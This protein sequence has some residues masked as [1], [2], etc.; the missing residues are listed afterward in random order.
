M[1]NDNDLFDMFTNGGEHQDQEKNARQIASDISIQSDP[2]APP[3][4]PH[5][6][7]EARLARK[8]ARQKKRRR[9]YALLLILAL[10][11]GIGFGGYKVFN[12]IKRATQSTVQKESQS[13]D[14]P[15]P[16]EGNVLFVINEGD[17][18]S[19]IAKNLVNAGVV[20][21]AGAFLKAVELADASKKLQVGSF[22][23]KKK[24]SAAQV[25]AIITDPSQISGALV[26]KP[27][28]R[29]TDIIKAAVQITDFSQEDFDAVLNDANAG[30]LPAV[31]QGN[32]EGWFEPGT[33]NAKNA[34]SAREI[35]SQMV[36][37]RIA[38]LKALNVTEDQY[39]T[40][41]IKA[42]IVEA[43]VN[44]SDYYGKV[45]RVIE[46]RLAQDM[47]LGMDSVVAYGL[48]IRGTE[49]TNAQLN[50]SSNP[51]NV[52][53]HKG[54]P[55]SAIGNPGDSAIKAVLEP[56]EGNW[57]YFVTVNLDTGETKFTDS[58]AQF[59]EYVK[60]LR[61]WEVDNPR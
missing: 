19:V 42:S 46:N 32:Y 27:G 35:I 3:L 59:E 4:P 31:A 17:D 25:V 37:K 23:L 29:N 15:G 13:L 55:P 56:E 49:L 47:S 54:L 51:Y 38:K 41:L 6:R 1:T 28:E 50:D 36:A 40:V 2:S 14:Y 10:I 61:Q 9:L 21:S 30:I 7:R 11:A 16:G 22:E 60:E 24:M 43:E 45:S 18:T 12:V 58:D 48:G 5:R 34:S 44:K 20:R 52:R 26:I 8:R 39:R 57:L 33:Y 53:I